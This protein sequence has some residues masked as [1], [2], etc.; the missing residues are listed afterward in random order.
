ML[1]SRRVY[2]QF[3]QCGVHTHQRDADA[4]G[5]IVPV[6][7]YPTKNLFGGITSLPSLTAPGG[8]VFHWLLPSSAL[9]RV[10]SRP[11]VSWNSRGSRGLDSSSLLAPRPSPAARLIFMTRSICFPVDIIISLRHENIPQIPSHCRLCTL[12]APAIWR[13]A[14][15]ECSSNTLLDD[16]LPFLGRPVEKPLVLVHEHLHRHRHL[17]LL[18]HCPKSL[19][20][21]RSDATPN[22]A[23]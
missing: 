15:P 22:S 12:V 10:A 17:L 2:S 16:C 21:I 9:A 5:D 11:T 7:G 13:S 18:L 23:T 8:G 19:S 20:P 6:P 1:Q 3:L 4:D 14:F